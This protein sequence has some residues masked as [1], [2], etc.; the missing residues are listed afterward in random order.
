MDSEAITFS[1]GENWR[2]YVDTVDE[3]S[4]KRASSAIEE[5][6]TS[7]QI[8]GRTV[9][10]IGCGSGIHSLCFHR[11]G[12]KQLVSVDVDPKSVESTRLMWNRAGS[13]A[14]WH[15]VHGS[16]LDD[17]F[18]AALG[19]A[20]IVYSWGVLHHTG[21]MWNAI[22]KAAS[23]VEKGGKFLIAIYVKGPKYPEH[24]ELKQSYNRASRLGKK[25]MVW[26]SVAKIMRDRWHM[27]LNPLAWNEKYDRGMDVY[28]DIVDWLGGL[29]YEV[30]SSDEIVAFC[31]ERGFVLEKLHELPEGGNN[32]YLFSLPK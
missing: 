9:L 32:T 7:D 20:E 25:L 15:V 27:G 24:L 23:R 19:K 5:W 18:T 21:A 22:D 16:I 2:S 1:F 26:Q 30:A 11:M 3:G 29:P 6:L 8:S 14:N 28:H 13:P 17:D 10:D 12:A 4:L 31:T